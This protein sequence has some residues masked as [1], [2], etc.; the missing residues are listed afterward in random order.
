MNKDSFLDNNINVEENREVEILER[1]NPKAFKKIKFEN[2]I[3]IGDISKYDM[4]IRTSNKART[5]GSTNNLVFTE[6]E[7]IK[8]TSSKKLSECEQD[9]YKNSSFDFTPK[10]KSYN[11]LVL[12]RI[13]DSQTLADYLSYNLSEEKWV[14]KNVFKILREIHLS[15]D[16]MNSNYQDSFKQYYKKTIDRLE[17][18]E[19]LFNDFNDNVIINGIEYRNPK[20]LLIKNKEKIESIFTKD[21]RFIHGD[22]QLSNILIDKNK[23]LWVIDPHGYFGENKLFG[24]CMYDFA[25]VYYGFCGM[26]DQFSK[27]FGYVEYIEK[28]Q[29]IIK[30]LI[31]IE[32]LKNRRELFFKEASKINYEK[33]TPLKIDLLHAIIWLSV[34]AYIS[35]DVLSS[36][37]GYLKGTILINNIFS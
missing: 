2:F 22:L 12:E 20:E 33:V 35:N 18:I 8:Y 23:K 15:K 3:D 36:L 7:V 4:E 26:Y 32:H 28:N 5:F 17:T 16:I 31:D 13:K 11:P 25:K 29:F 10:I 14:I 9:W 6:E 24:D 30:D 34:S 1:L 37:Y 19:F 27:G 21:F